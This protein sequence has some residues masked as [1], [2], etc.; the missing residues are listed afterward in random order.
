M[1]LILGIALII[2][3][4]LIGALS[5]GLLRVEQTRPA[6]LPHISVSGGQAPAFNVDTARV[7][8]GSEKRVVEVPKLGTEKK[9]IDVPIVTVNKAGG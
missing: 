6:E 3:L 8:L 1:R 9:A 4:L 5:L 2:V 7:S